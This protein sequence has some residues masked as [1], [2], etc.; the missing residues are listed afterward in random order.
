MKIKTDVKLIKPILKSFWQ[1]KERD[2]EEK[3]DLTYKNCYRN[4]SNCL[5][6]LHDDQ[7]PSRDLEKF[8]IYDRFGKLTEI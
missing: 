5:K 4:L 1:G 7:A 8:V 3:R 2:Y 6:D